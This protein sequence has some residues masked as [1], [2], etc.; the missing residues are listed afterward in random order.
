MILVFLIWSTAV[1]NSLLY[2]LGGFIFHLFIGKM[3][4]AIT[5]F[6]IFLGLVGQ[7]I[8]FRDFLFTLFGPVFIV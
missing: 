8:N 1:H 2:F 6:S 5:L 3:W 7:L 4:I